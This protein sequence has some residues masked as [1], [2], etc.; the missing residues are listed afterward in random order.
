MKLWLLD[1][2]VIID[3]I[4]LKVFDK[5]ATLHEINAASTVIDEVKYY[6]RDGVQVPI[7][8]RRE[9][10]DT[11]IVSEV[12]AEPEELA[13]VLDHIPEHQ[14]SVIHGGELESMAVLVRRDD[15]V[16]CSCDAA[17]IRALPFLD[18]SG[19]GISV[20]RLLKTSGLTQSSFEDRHKE[21]YFKSNLDIG[22]RNKLDHLFFNNPAPH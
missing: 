5:L 14:R 22:K 18:L 20:E 19:R 11:G 7:P 16:F 6:I 12:S 1:A 21:A 4:R 15:L 3:L 13:E 8:F 2:D 17:T 10:V 9:Y